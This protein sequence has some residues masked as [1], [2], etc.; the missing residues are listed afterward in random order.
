MIISK[1]RVYE[2]ALSSIKEKH[3][4]DF[5]KSY[6]PSVSPIMAEYGGRFLINGAIR[7]SAV[8]KFPARSFAILEW[9][10]IERFIAI[11][12]DERMLPLL[13]ARNQYLDFIMEGCFFR[14]L[15]NATFEI[16]ENGSMSL[17]L[18]ER[19]LDEGHP[20]RLQWIDNI[21]NRELSS[22]LYIGGDSAKQYDKDEDL[23]ELTVHVLQRG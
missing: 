15:E 22:N 3:V 1:T 23:E 16:P 18:S 21:E 5:L 6:I 20:L 7:D 17:L 8:K 10:S 12:K 19:V 13:E 4:D 2:L 9:P 11:N 14:A